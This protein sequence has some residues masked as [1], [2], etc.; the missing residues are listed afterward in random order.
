M[1]GRVTAGYLT[2]HYHFDISEDEEINYSLFT[3]PPPLPK[4]SPQRTPTISTLAVD[5][6]NLHNNSKQLSGHC[7]RLLRQLQF[8]LWFILTG[9][10]D[11][12]QL[13]AG[14]EIGGGGGL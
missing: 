1:V 13:S 11:V 6:V 5:A 14:S 7:P 3:T 4:A 2:L 9:G 12:T 8:D 10:D